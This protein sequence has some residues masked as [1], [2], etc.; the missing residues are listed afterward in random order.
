MIAAFSPPKAHRRRPRRSN[1]IERAVQREFKHRI[2]KARA[3]PNEAS[4]EWLVTAI[5]V[6][7]DG[8]RA[9][10]DEP[11]ISLSTNDAEHSHPELLD[12]RLRSQISSDKCSG[13]FVVSVTTSV[14]SGARL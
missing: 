9:A 8:K 11:S 4:L 2:V 10:I 6:E 12:I 5:L 14:R 3:C 7:I 13:G 1:P